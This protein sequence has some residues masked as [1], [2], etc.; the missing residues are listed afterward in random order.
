MLN[1]T[2]GLSRA[3]VRG[4]MGVSGLLSIFKQV[5]RMAGRACA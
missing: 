4:A 3:L 1:E 2:S 5:N